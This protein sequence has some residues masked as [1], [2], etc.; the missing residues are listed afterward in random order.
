MIN[1][2]EEEVPQY[3]W[4]LIQEVAGMNPQEELETQIDESV[5]RELYNEAIERAEFRDYSNR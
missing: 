1:V 4:D 5:V 2:E 3:Y